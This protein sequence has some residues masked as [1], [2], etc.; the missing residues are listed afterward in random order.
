LQP[1]AEPARLRGAPSSKEGS[2]GYPDRRVIEY[3]GGFFDD[4]G[5]SISVALSV[6]SGEQDEA[7]RSWAE[8]AHPNLV[9][10]NEVEGG[11]HGAACERPQLSGEEI[12]GGF[13]L[14]P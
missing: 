6:V 13:G 3:K 5:A 1:R 12:R 10:W 9:S 11:G 4:T 14:L 8:W 2:H 7:P